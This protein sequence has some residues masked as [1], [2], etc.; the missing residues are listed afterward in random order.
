MLSQGTAQKTTRELQLHWENL[1]HENTA[2]C[3]RE[4]YL[5]SRALICTCRRSH[6]STHGDTRLLHTNIRHHEHKHSLFLFFVCLF[7]CLF[8]SSVSQQNCLL[9]GYLYFILR[10][11]FK[12]ILQAVE[13]LG[14][15]SL[16][17]LCILMWNR[18]FDSESEI[19]FIA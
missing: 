7:V 2:E 19:F 3:E 14:S 10:K 8:L 9:N 5:M 4:R 17:L 12:H 18:K 15:Q 6:L 1:Y 16:L 13:D 11:K